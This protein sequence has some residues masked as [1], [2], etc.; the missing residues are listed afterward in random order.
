MKRGPGG[1]SPRF[2][3]QHGKRRLVETIRA[4]TLVAGDSRLATALSRRGAV[5]QYKVREKLAIQGDA[6]N[7]IFLILSGSVAIRVNGRQV[8]VRSAG[9]HVG[10]M[11][12]VD[13]LAVRSATV[14]AIERTVT[15]R[16]KE[17]HFTNLGVQYPQLWR[18]I[19][20]EVANRL[21]ERNKQV[22]T[23]NSKP[24]LFIGSSQEGVRIAQE[25]EKRI[26]T[27]AIITRIWTDGVFEASK[28]NIESL[29]GQAQDIDFAAIV[30]TGDDV[31]ISRRKKKPSPRDNLIFEL[32][33]FMGAIGRERVFIVKPR[34]LDVK[35]PSD[36]L[37][38]TCVEYV[39]GGP[40]PFAKRFTSACDELARAIQKNGSR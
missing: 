17:H 9:T 1:S 19:A 33:L 35:I 20:A 22:R 26:R 2:S 3:G 28:T 25:I 40:V 16:V 6:D 8:A 27:T 34:R 24:V 39:S 38:V 14:V 37:G 13:P 15:L 23:P 36:L 21:R 31:T 12:L 11:A 5:E 30:L 7:D 29:L 10:E 32:G 4:Q 18:R